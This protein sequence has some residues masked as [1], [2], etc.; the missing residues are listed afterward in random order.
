MPQYVSRYVFVVSMLIALIAGTVAGGAA[1]FFAGYF[2]DTSAAAPVGAP[3]LLIVPSDEQTVMNIVKRDL[4]SVV[5]ISVSE[6]ISRKTSP[7]LYYQ[8][9]SSSIAN[10]PDVR[11]KIGGGSGF[12]VSQDG[13][14]VT[15]RHVV[16][17]AKA[18]YTVVLQDGTTY[19]AKVLD[20]DPSLDL[21]ILKVDIAHAPSL[22]LG[23]SDTIQIGQTVLAIGNA[24]AQFQNSVTKGIISGTNRRVL[25]DGLGGSELI[26]EAIQTDA[27][28]NPGNSGG[29]LIDL[30]G[31]VIG[32]TTAVSGDGQSLGFA[33][34]SNAVK[35]AVESVKKT[36]HII[37]PWLG[38]RYFMINDDVAE[39]NNLPVRYGA[40][41]SRGSSPKD[42]AVAPGSP[43]DKAGIL[44]NDIILQV[45]GQ[46][47]TDDHSLASVLS[48]F[49]P[50]DQ[51]DIQV[52]RH[53][54][55]KTLKLILDERAPVA[56]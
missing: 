43:A 10:L 5:A 7:H 49:S 28:I 35:Q 12:F 25:A 39:T 54:E 27:A 26:E 31:D 53:G 42:A 47:L 20:R 40:L 29:P 19:P 56:P 37:R 46:K 44:E 6:K 18:D 52:L 23:D 36:G 50:G 45:Q 32:V 9:P 30:R 1:A 16:E 4:P 15:N 21:A 48:R 22:V 38:V 8:G 24:L 17:D 55:E 2:A 33:I 14:I 13:L 34:P 3:E 41:V 51:V 11:R